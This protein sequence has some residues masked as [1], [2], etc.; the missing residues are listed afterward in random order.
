MKLHFEDQHGGINAL[1]RRNFLFFLIREF[2]YISGGQQL[3][4]TGTSRPWPTSSSG[5]G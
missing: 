2:S 4:P 1:S 5:C 3:V